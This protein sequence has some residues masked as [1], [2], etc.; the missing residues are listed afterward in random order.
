[1]FFIKKFVGDDLLCVNLIDSENKFEDALL[2]AMLYCEQHYNKI[3]PDRG[4]IIGA[5]FSDV[6]HPII[7]YRFVTNNGT[8]VS[9]LV[10]ENK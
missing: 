8:I 1:M 5:V 6:A 3:Y 9:Y 2:L 4:Q 7:G 10:K